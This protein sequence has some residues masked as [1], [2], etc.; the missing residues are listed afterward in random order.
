ML[1]SVVAEGRVGGRPVHPGD[2]LVL[3]TF[4]A[5]R[6]AGRFDP[7]AN[8][9]A[10]LKQLWFGAGAHFCLGAPLA[11][12]QIQRTIT[13][14]LDAAAATPLAVTAR[15]AQRGALIPA[16]RSLTLARA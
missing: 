10:S 1:R 5:N 4:L 9:A 6:G 12:A 8:P 11:M 3:A 7:V 14:V 16:Y 2:R 13:A 15:S